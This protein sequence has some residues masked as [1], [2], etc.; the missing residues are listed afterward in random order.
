MEATP[1]DQFVKK[2]RN[3]MDGTKFDRL[4]KSIATQRVSR[5]TALRGLAAGA[6]ASFTGLTLFGEDGEAK[7]GKKTRKRRICHRTSATDP[8]VNRRLKVKKAKR[9]LRNH[10]FDTKGRCS[11]VPAPTTAAPGPTTAPPVGADCT[12]DADCGGGLIC[13]GGKC[14]LCQ[15]NNQ[16]P[17][18]QICITGQCRGGAGDFFFGIGAENCDTSPVDCPE[19]TEC[20]QATE[21]AGD[22]FLCLLDDQDMGLCFPRSDNVCATNCDNFCGDAQ[23]DDVAGLCILGACTIPGDSDACRACGGDNIAEIC[24]NLDT[25]PNCDST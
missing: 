17:G 6:V 5:L 16:C 9:H 1:R 12:V 24:M 3:H 22:P 11:A 15:N 23:V 19:P 2:D 8:G 4:I 18:D 20:R 21:L 25:D 10:Q 7:D 13:L 14:R